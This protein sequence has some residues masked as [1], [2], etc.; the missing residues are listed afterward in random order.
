MPDAGQTPNDRTETALAYWRGFLSTTGRAAETPLYDVFHFDDN[1]ENANLLA[2][3]VLS[4]TKQATA[5]LPWEYEG[6]DQRVPMAGDLSVVTNWSGTPMCVIET[7]QVDVTPFDEVDAAFAA[8]EGEGDGSLQFWRTV[9]DA[10]F[11][12]LCAAHGR[13]FSADMD[14]VCERFRVIFR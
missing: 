13:Q 14:V 4:G 9:H 10:Y 6:D 3:L 11:T 2:E 5:S 12:R 7:T 8:A 1:E